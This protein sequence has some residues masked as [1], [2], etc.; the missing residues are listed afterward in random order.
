MFMKLRGIYE[1]KLIDKNTG[2][3]D[4]EGSQKNTLTDG[5]I[6]GQ[7]DYYGIGSVDDHKN[8]QLAL[9]DTILPDGPEYRS[10]DVANTYITALETT[11]ILTATENVPS[12]SFYVE[13]NF[14]A[15]VSPRTIRIIGLHWRDDTT[16]TW[17]YYMSFVN[18][19]TPI[20]QSASQILYVRYTLTMEYAGGLIDAAD[21]EFIGIYGNSNPWET[22]RYFSAFRA[23]TLGCQ[24][25]PTMFMNPVDKNLVQRR[26]ESFLAAPSRVSEGASFTHTWTHSIGTTDSTGPLGALIDVYVTTGAGT[27]FPLVGYFDTTQTPSISRV[28]IHPSTSIDEIFSDPGDPPMSRGS[29]S[30][31]GT[32]TNI[33]P[34]INRLRITKTGK[35]VDTTAENFF[36]TDVDTTNNRITIA[37]E[38]WEVDDVVRFSNTGGT[39]PSPIGDGTDYYIVD[40]TGSSPS[41]ELQISTTEGGAALNITDSGDGTHTIT[42]QSEGRYSL[43]L[44]AYT[45]SGLTGVASR[46]SGNNYSDFWS[47]SVNTCRVY[48]SVMGVDSSGENL[49]ASTS[50]ILTQTF[51]GRD[52]SFIYSLQ[53]RNSSSAYQFCRWR[54][55]TIETAEALEEVGPAG[56]EI[57]SAAPAHGDYEG[58]VFVA[59]DN[60]VYDAD[61]TG[62]SVSHL[63][64][65]NLIDDDLRD[66]SYDQ[67]TGRLWTAHSTG[68]SSVDL[69][70][71]GDATQYTTSNYLSG[72]SANAVNIPWGGIHAHNNR[73][74]VIRPRINSTTESGW[75]FDDTGLDGTKG[76]HNYALTYLTGGVISTYDNTIVLRRYNNW[77]RYDTTVG[78]SNPLLESYA[79]SFTNTGEIGPGVAQISERQFVGYGVSPSSNRVNQEIFKTGVGIQ[80][81]YELRFDELTDG[82]SIYRHQPRILLDMSEGFG[83]YLNAMTSFDN[84]RWYP[85]LVRHGNYPFQWGYGWD[86]TA[87][88]RGLL[89][90]DMTSNIT[91]D[92]PIPKSGHHVGHDMTASFSNSGGDPWDEQFIAGERVTFMSAPVVVKDNLQEYS[93]KGRTYMGP[94]QRV[95]DETAVISALSNNFTVD[96]TN[97]PT[98]L[99]DAT[100]S[101]WKV[102]DRV[103]FTSTGTLPSPLSDSTYYFVKTADTTGLTISTT[104][105]GGAVTFTDDGDGTHTVTTQFGRYAVEKSTYG[106]NPDA[107]FRQM[108]SLDWLLRLYNVT[109]GS[110][111][112]AATIVAGTPPDSN[113]YYRYT[114]GQFDFNESNLDKT[115]VITYNYTQYL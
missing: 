16:L 12:R 35:A 113:D 58:H 47:S 91:Y 99:L 10:Y 72:L 104:V 75:L 76:Y 21:N 90:P 53:H 45:L 114:A 71:G 69:L 83:V 27:E 101:L 111:M 42:T 9:S 102:N 107:D 73:V 59:T 108:D 110:D 88:V 17:R 34:L 18:L 37:S 66:V 15:P 105:G 55:A 93:L 30:V 25:Q 63:N 80:S 87:W 38:D 68:L 33:W 94:A 14:A 43:E 22:L 97:S 84:G 48:N 57:R 4:S 13:N 28:F 77:Y 52:G 112:T 78:G 46:P 39:L 19:T 54:F 31:T 6:A 96:S 61:L 41:I 100:S 81:T 103:D 32:P 67:V 115:M 36:N 56:M 1:W 11:G 2:H 70:G 62:A 98:Y 49:S 106:S 109:D 85:R 64:I 89:T 82:F 44:E 26:P 7:Q 5:F 86:G 24:L 95:T 65:T 8:Y 92:R 60:G 40:T 3:V 23:G 50:L 74:L 20:T 29:V 51:L 79:S